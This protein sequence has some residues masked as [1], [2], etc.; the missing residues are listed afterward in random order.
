MKLYVA[1]L[2][3]TVLRLT[4]A[5]AQLL[6][7]PGYVV[8]AAGDTLR[9]EVRQ[10]DNKTLLFRNNNKAVERSYSPELLV[11]Y[12]AE[13]IDYAPVQL[14]EEGI[15]SSYFMREQIKGYVSLYSLFH[16]E[17]RMTHALRLPDNTFV[18][19]RGNLA[20]LTLT[21]HL[22]ECK[23]AQMS[24]LL[25]LGSFYNSEVYYERVVNTYNQ[26]VRPSQRVTQT[27][28]R[29]RYEAGLSAIGCMNSWKYGTSDP[30][31]TVYYNPY[32]VY[33]TFYTGT[34]GAFFT[35]V[36]RKRLSISVELLASKYTGSLTVPLTN[37]LDPTA[38]N[39]RLYSFDERYFS[40]PVTGRYV[41]INRATRWYLKAG[42]GP[43]LRTA[44]SGKYTEV[45]VDADIFINHKTNIGVGFLAGLGADIPLTEKHRIYVE[46]R[47][48]PH[49][50]LDGVTRIATSR[51]LQFTINVPLIKRE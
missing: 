32:N 3:F 29:F 41:F 28:K 48:M 47:T 12:R 8:T 6:F 45:N 30:I 35:V 51:S 19:L 40:L 46:L 42:V 26:C 4:S 49:F 18:P 11:T 36:P 5:T 15:V 24:H 43:T 37:P 7:T 16:A 22:T 23:S 50:V 14:T 27:K 20:L 21:K 17:G 44:M 9:G 13:G 1:I 31:N 10:K 38:V 2:L 34:I 33:S 39:P 25:S